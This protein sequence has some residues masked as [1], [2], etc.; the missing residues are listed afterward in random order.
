MIWFPYIHWAR[1]SSIEYCWVWDCC[2]EFY[3]WLPVRCEWSGQFWL[4]IVK[5]PESLS[6]INKLLIT[7]HFRQKNIVSGRRRASLINWY[8][9][10]FLPNIRPPLFS[11]MVF[12]YQWMF[13]SWWDYWISWFEESLKKTKLKSLF[14][15]LALVRF[16][17]NSRWYYFLIAVVCILKAY[18]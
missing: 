5:I 4:S 1:A 14:R 18:S 11:L 8:R 16:E 15:Y 12:G 13:Y 6:Q 3:F 10:Y 9:I 7:C 2:C 17:S